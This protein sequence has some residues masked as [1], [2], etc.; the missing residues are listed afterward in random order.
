[1]NTQ[2]YIRKAKVRQIKNQL[3]SPNTPSYVRKQM[4]AQLRTGFKLVSKSESVGWSRQEIASA[5][6]LCETSW[7][8]MV[9]SLF[10]ADCLTVH[11]D[12]VGSL[13]S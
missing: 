13:K 3:Y 4:F 1:M 7:T 9:L 8:K 10:A 12:L 5:V 2:N 6:H 11:S